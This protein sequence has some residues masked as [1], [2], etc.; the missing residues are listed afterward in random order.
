MVLVEVVV[1]I[2]VEEQE[3]QLQIMILVGPPEVVVV[4]HGLVQVI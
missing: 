1:D 3:L 2:M 4:L